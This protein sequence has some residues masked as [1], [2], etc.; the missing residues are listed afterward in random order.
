[1]NRHKSELS[2]EQWGK[3]SSLPARTP[4][5]ALGWA[6]TNSQSS[7]LRGYLMGPSQWRMLEGP[8]SILSFSQHLLASSVPVGGTRG[9]A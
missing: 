3:N 1:M 4:S 2:D 8:A 6:Q 9:L 5:F 7:L